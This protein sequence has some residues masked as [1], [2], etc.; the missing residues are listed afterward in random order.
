MNHHHTFVLQDKNDPE[1]PNNEDQTKYSGNEGVTAKL[2][3]ML[4][5][6]AQ[7]STNDELSNTVAQLSENVHS[8]D[9]NTKMALAKFVNYAMHAPK[10]ESVEK[11]T[12]I[13]AEVTTQLRN[14]IS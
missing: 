14:K 5:Y 12:A 8:M 13:D 6:I 10:T 4:S 11:S 7:R 9:Q 2:S 1:N 3:S